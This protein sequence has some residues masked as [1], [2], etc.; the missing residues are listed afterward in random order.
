MINK[1]TIIGNLGSD[2]ELRYTQG[3]EPVCNFSVATSTSWTDKEGQKQQS[4]EWHRIVVWGKPAEA[5]EKYLKKGKQVYIEGPIKTRSWEDKDGTKRYTV[6]IN[7]NVV[8]FLGNSSSDGYSNSSESD[9]S[10]NATGEEF[11]DDDIPF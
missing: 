7:A 6:E 5:C 8:Q 9:T 4:T 10:N 11:N 2:P 1:A 3:G